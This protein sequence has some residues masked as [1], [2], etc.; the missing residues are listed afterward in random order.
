MP[1]GTRGNSHV[2]ALS[3]SPARDESVVC[4]GIFSK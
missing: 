4:V 1:T 2:P 3:K